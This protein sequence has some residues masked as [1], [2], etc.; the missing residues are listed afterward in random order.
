MI[1]CRLS[2]ST[3]LAQGTW[4]LQNNPTSEAGESMQFVSATEGWIGLM[5]NQLLHTT[6]AGALWTAVT[7]NSTD[8][9]FGMDAPGSRISFIN[10]ST[11]WVLKSL[12][13][14][15]DN[16]SGAVLY[17]TTDNG[18]NWNRTVLSN[19][20]GDIG[21]Q[22]QF[23][24]ASYGWVSIYNFNTMVITFKKTTDGGAN[25][26]PTNGGGIF[27]Y[28]NATTGYAFSAG[29]DMQPPYYIMKTTDGGAN[30]T[31]QYTDITVGELNAI[32]FTDAN[33]GWIVGNN[34][35]IFHTINGGTNW[36]QITNS[37]YNV[38]YKNSAISFINNT[39]GW[40]ASTDDSNG[41][42]FTLSTTDGG[43]NWKTQTLTLC[44][45]VFSMYFW[46]ANHG[47]ATSDSGPI[48]KYSISTGPYSNAT[49]NG[50]WFFYSDVTPIDPFNDNLMYF[51]FNGNGNIEDVSGFGGPFTGNYTVSASGEIA[52]KITNG[53]DCFLFGGQLTSTT[54]GTAIADGQNFRLHIKR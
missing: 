25:W 33:N 21:V 49:L 20:P 30:W 36:T 48:A 41:N 24:D 16:P 4:S 9:T 12:G 19:T 18:L 10:P 47:W 32:E 42:H 43:L 50:P 45:D 6:N 38:N 8:V 44:D 53:S 22:V 7:P 5:S 34:G 14:D 28:V 39:T 35:K 40:I 23:I 27:C 52:A 2:N 54:E 3:A 46:D 11:G 26:T 37:A 13:A 1:F 17:K 15:Y 51:V 29:P 31:Q